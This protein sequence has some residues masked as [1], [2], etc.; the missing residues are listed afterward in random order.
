MNKNYSYIRVV[1]KA[2][3]FGLVLGA[4][5][6]QVA[7]AQVGGQVATKGL[8]PAANTIRSYTDASIARDS[9]FHQPL[10]LLNDF[11]PTIEVLVS[12]HD[13]VRRRSDIEESDL[14]FTVSPGLAYR[15]NIGRHDFYASYAGV[16][17]F[18]DDLDQ[19]ESKSNA[20]NA[21]LG[22]DLA[23][24]WDLRLFG[25][26]GD[27]IE[28]RGVSGSRAFNTLIIGAD[29]GPDKFKYERY[30]A[31]LAFGEKGRR[32]VG[33][34]GI[35]KNDSRY[36]NN[37][38]GEANQF[39]GRDRES[40]SI[41]LDLSYQIGSK[42]AIFGRIQN[43][44]IDY[45]RQINTLDNEQDDF[46]VGLRWKPTNRLSGAVA[47]G[48]SDRDYDLP[49]RQ[50]YDDNTYYVNLNYA[51]SPF[52]SLS[53]AAS[54]ILE[55][56]GDSES[57]FY[58]S[59]LFGLGYDH[60]VSERV[61][62]NAYAKWIDDD[63]NTQREDKFVDFGLGVDYAFR[64]WLTAGLFVGDIERDSSINE[65]DYRDQYVGIRLR[66]DLRSLLRTKD[67]PDSESLYSYPRVYDR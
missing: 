46:L 52:A 54:R 36:I 65:L 56:P 13:N 21:H 48:T 44:D 33:V 18:Y 60:A 55:E 59:E 2:L 7:S 32:L 14:K 42:T 9:E 1:S 38:Q 66:S 34:L 15:T 24:D 41:H 53:V 29:N 43:T 40:T 25:G 39:G 26:F 47:V 67:E 50:G 28:E 58:E 16:F 63:Y 31:D 27:G 22:L 61:S 37:F 5:A 6:L 3:C 62:F 11:Y 57:D 20:V 51:F 12:H 35:E 4:T 49:G 45:D 30:G 17:T 10:D 19:E 23:Q 64:S 8:T